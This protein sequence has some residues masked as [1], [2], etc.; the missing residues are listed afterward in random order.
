MLTNIKSNTLIKYFYS[1]KSLGL[2]YIAGS[3]I[4]S[5]WT[6]LR[7]FTKMSVYDLVGQQNLSYQWIH[8]FHS[9]SILGVTNYVLKMC[10]VYI[11][12]QFLPGSPRFK[13]VV[14]TLLIN[15]ATFVLVVSLVRKIY[16]LFSPKARINNLIFVWFALL[17][18]SV[19]WIE[20]ANSRNLEVVGG[21]LLVYLILRQRDAKGYKNAFIIWVVASLLFFAD[22]LQLAVSAIPVL[23]YFVVV[24]FQKKKPVRNRNLLLVVLALD[25]GILF[26]LLFN[27]FLKKCLGAQASQSP[28]FNLLGL[29]LSGFLNSVLDSVKQAGRLFVGGH[30]YGGVVEALDLGFSVLMLVYGLFLSLKKKLN[31]D[32]IVFWIIYVFVN[33]TVYI[34][35]GQSIRAQTSRYLIMCVPV[36]LVLFLHIFNA[37]KK[38]KTGLFYLLVGIVAINLTAL[39]LI[40]IPS[41]SSPTKADAHQY[42]IISYLQKNRIEVAYG[43]MYAGMTADYYSNQSVAILPLVCTSDNKLL[44]TSLFFDL[45]Y[46]KFKAYSTNRLVPVI[47]DGNE[48]SNV[49]THCG[50]G[51]VEEMFGSPSRVDGLSDGSSVLFYPAQTLRRVLF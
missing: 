1:E 24:N 13:L 32:I 25:G 45:S 43:G 3:I 40:F 18:G 20:F 50:L 49:D 27:V 36:T 46:Y 31:L 14:M 10:L 28:K 47:L 39:L 41:L 4:V 19:Y 48:I 30:E 51:V 9:N 35:C 2:V 7:F 38:Y 37:D 8:G 22:L 6:L 42:A 29:G 34:F 15:I 44:V 16:R 21:L 12:A 26:W 23:L 17:S 5:I 11:P 33:F